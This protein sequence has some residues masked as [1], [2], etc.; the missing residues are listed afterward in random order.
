[1]GGRNEDLVAEIQAGK[2]YLI[3][4]LWKENKG[5]IAKV[6]HLYMGG[7]GRLYDIDDL[8]QAGFLGLYTAAYL[9]SPE[10]GAKFS[11]FAPFYIRKAMR[12]AAGLCGK[13]DPLIDA[14]SLDEPFSDEDDGTLLDI[15]PAPEDKYGIYQEDT[16]RIMHDAVSHIGNEYARK[17]IEAV[18]WNGESIQAYAESEGITAA[19]VSARLQRGYCSLRRSKS[20]VSLAI[21]EGYQPKYVKGSW[22]SGSPEDI[23]ISKDQAE[24][25]QEALY[26]H[27]GVLLCANAP[28]DR[29]ASTICIDSGRKWFRCPNCG[30]KHSIFGKL[31]ECKGVFLKC[32]RGC[33]Q[34]FELV[35]ENGKQINP[36]TGEIMLSTSPH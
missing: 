18:Y 2:S 28:R 29:T 10:R 6:A 16:T 21:A 9:Y 13:S 36:G 27:L 24:R 33:K 5:L 12:E 25:R 22:L 34:T 4:T 11:S 20:V 1:M 30:A 32:D 17:A 3:E 14:K 19:S 35:I 15:I 26:K 23:I 8:L 7:C 31:A